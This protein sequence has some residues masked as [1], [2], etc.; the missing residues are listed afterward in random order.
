MTGAGRPTLSSSGEAVQS[1]VAQIAAGDLNGALEA[2]SGL[3]RRVISEPICTSRVFS[4]PVLDRLCA[5]V[6]RAA[7]ESPRDRHAG[8]EALVEDT[9]IFVATRLQAAGGHTRVME[10]F[11]RIL[12]HVNKLLL[13]T[14]LSGR[15]D[16]VDAAHRFGALGAQIEYAPRENLLGRL[17]WL[18][19]RVTDLRGRDLYLFNH[20][21]DCVA[22]AAMESAGRAQ[23][24][25]YHHGDHHLCLGVHLANARHID[26]HSFGYHNCRHDLKVENNT[27]LPLVAE[28]LGAR[29]P[30]MPF[31]SGGVLTTCTAAGWNKLEIPHSV[32]YT[33][34]IPALLA[35]TG[36][37]HVHIGKLTPLGLWR[38]RRR[39]NRYGV[40]LSAFVYIP[41]VASV[42]RSLHEYAVDLYVSSFPVTGGRTMVEV[43][44]A[45]IPI[46]VHDHPTSRFLGGIDMAYEGAYSW[47]EP[48]ELLALC[49]E[50]TDIQLKEHSEKARLH[51]S[52][53]HAPDLLRR[54]LME[55]QE[56]AVPP[57]QGKSHQV[58][59]LNVALEIE[60]QTTLLACLLKRLRRNYLRGRA[61]LSQ[62]TH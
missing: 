45:G 27:Y 22:V 49:A 5:L 19:R 60:R 31:R 48:D 23:V 58:D 39:L 25:F 10:D 15:S 41:R 35:A 11:L 24:H 29:P 32:R 14:G 26:I 62:K 56:C 8:R 4:S 42:W 17:Q 13:V 40:P 3:A 6:G 30:G 33:E 2:I 36:G 61:W 47:R 18:Q 16:R 53:F 50:A 28:D 7:L 59:G 55:G 1:I 12:P 44:G 9:V 54:A 37:R 46:A 51:Y 52:R 38:I 57:L 21:E 20:H 34:I 43:M